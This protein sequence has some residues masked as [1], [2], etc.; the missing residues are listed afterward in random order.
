[1]KV[2]Y[3]EDIAT[4]GDEQ[5][6][7]ETIPHKAT[8]V[9]ILTVG[10]MLIVPVQP[11]SSFFEDSVIPRIEVN[12]SYKGTP[13]I[14]TDTLNHHE[15][16]QVLSA[17]IHDIESLNNNWDG[18]GAIAIPKLIVENARCFLHTLQEKSI[19]INDPTDVY[20]TPYGTIVI[21]YYN[22]KGLVSMEIDNHRIGFF[23]DYKTSGN[24]GAEGLDTNFKDIP[25]EL[26]SHLL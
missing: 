3:K 19:E 7:K 6:Y 14:P 11:A 12:S 20:P 1:M 13:F 18:Y 26:A 25:M 5:L 8:T 9:K 2:N 4:M 22:D 16:N 17:R 23:T 15:L 21:E 10:A 24:W